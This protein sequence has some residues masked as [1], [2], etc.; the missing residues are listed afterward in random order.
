MDRGSESHR[1]LKYFQFGQSGGLMIT[2]DRKDIKLYFS[3]ILWSLLPSIYLLVRMKIVAINDVNIN[4]LGQMEWFDLIDETITTMLIVPLYSVLKPH[5]SDVYKVGFAFVISFLIYFI[6]TILIASKV[7]TIAVFMKAEYATF[8]LLFQTFSM[9]VQFI[10]TFMILVLTLNCANKE[11]NILVI[12]KLVC[13]SILDSI[14]INR[15]NDI[16]AAYSEIVTNLIIAITS[17]V[18]IYKNKYMIFRNT[19]IIFVKEWTKAGIPVGVQIF[20]DNFIYA[21]MIVRMVN[22]VNESGNYWVANNFIWGWLLVPVLC[23]AEIIKKNDLDKLTFNNTWKYGIEIILLWLVTMPFWRF[24]IKYG[25][26]INDEKIW[27]IVIMS[28]PFY[29]T[30]IVSAFL[31]AW[32]VS[33]GNTKYLMYI[34]LFVNV[35]YYGIVFNLFKMNV[36]NVNMNFIILMFGFGM[37]VHMILSIIFYAIEQ[38]S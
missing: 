10:V 15:F 29:V 36:F 2:N 4:I 26:S 20:L 12:S 14:F 31:D 5:K 8:Y 1:E 24:F 11:I 21:I 23:F 33:K 17:I 22:A 3:L 30:Y 9:L 19:D 13:L 27:S 18:L 38:R 37:I 6:F 25:M 28:V 7:S 35:V 34:S 32:F 16:G